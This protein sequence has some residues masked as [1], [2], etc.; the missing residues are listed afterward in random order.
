ML[1]RIENERDRVLILAHVGLDISLRNLARA[2]ETNRVELAARVS[3]ILAKLREDAELADML[4][5]IHRAG[6]NDRYQALVFRLG[7]QDWFC[8]Y[9]GEFMLQ[10]ERG[11]KRKTCSNTCRYKLWES[12]GIGWKNQHHALPAKVSQHIPDLRHPSSVE[13]TDQEKLLALLQPIEAGKRRLEDWLPSNTFWWQPETQSRDRALLLLGFMCP[14]SLS[15]SDL[16]ALDIDDIAQKRSGLEVRLHRRANK[17]IRYVTFPTSTDPRL[18]P[19]T[20]ISDW[21]IRLIRTGRTDGPLFMRMDSRGQLPATS[22]R[23]TGR[24]IAGVIKNA[25]R[26]G[27]FSQ[28]SGGRNIKLDVSTPLAEFLNDI[29]RPQHSE[30]FS[31]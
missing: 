26:C 24:A 9:C 10:S 13:S 11:V 20:A 14:I 19:V 6:Q 23:L 31:S 15:S 1:S 17:G 30:P 28:R 27:Y 22:V 3:A 29:F 25:A 16:A 4:G 18:C 5:D 12:H 21:R 8:S 7:L 2:M